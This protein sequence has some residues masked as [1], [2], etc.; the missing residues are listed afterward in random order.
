MPADGVDAGSVL[1][2]AALA[3]P[4][5]PWR[6]CGTG[7]PTLAR[8]LYRGLPLVLLALIATLGIKAAAARHRAHPGGT[9]PGDADAM[10][11]SSGRDLTVPWLGAARCTPAPRSGS[12]AWSWR[13][14]PTRRGCRT[15]CC[16]TARSPTWGPRLRAGPRA[17][18]A[19]LALL[20]IEDLQVAAD[21]ETFA[22][23]V[24]VA[25]ER[26]G[27]ALSPEL[28]RTRHGRDVPGRAEGAV[29]D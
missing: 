25:G 12:S 5:A 16:C 13:C 28:R 22:A 26:P 6:Q 17:A 19:H 2:P 23:E 14:W 3:H 29:H 18:G 8:G 10:G 24:Q 15:A 20:T 7:W 11:S 27:G 4:P 1:D 9:G 21:A